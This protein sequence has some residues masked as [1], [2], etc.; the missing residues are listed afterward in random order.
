MTHISEWELQC[1]DKYSP[2]KKAKYIA[3]DTFLRRMIDD[4][5]DVLLR[6]AV[7]GFNYDP[8]DIENQEPSDFF[9]FDTTR[10]MLVSAAAAMFTDFFGTDHLHAIWANFL[11]REYQ[12][13]KKQGQYDWEDGGEQPFYSGLTKS[14]RKQ[15]INVN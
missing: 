11:D 3:C 1:I 2:E 5:D 7:K 6:K 13:R 12:Q 9:I 8:D 15:G 10:H 14:E 4:M